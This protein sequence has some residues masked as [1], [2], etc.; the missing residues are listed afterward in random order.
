MVGNLIGLIVLVAVGIRLYNTDKE[1][2]EIENYI[3]EHMKQDRIY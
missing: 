2:D 1:R 3:V